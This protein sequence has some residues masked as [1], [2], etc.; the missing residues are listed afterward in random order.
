MEGLKIQ[1]Q[2]YHIRD[3]FFGWNCVEQ[4]GLKAIRQAAECAH[5]EAQWFY[6]LL[7]D[8]TTDGAIENTLRR[9]ADI[10]NCHRASCFLA[11]FLMPRNPDFDFLMKAAN[12]A[13]PLAYA[14]LSMK[15]RDND[16]SFITAQLS[17]DQGEREGFFRLAKCYS[18]KKPYTDECLKNEFLNLRRAA[19]LHCTYSMNRLV[20]ALDPKC[21]ERWHWMLKAAKLG[22][23]FQLELII[24]HIENHR[25]LPTNV[26]FLF[27]YKFT[28]YGEFIPNHLP[29]AKTL[30]FRNQMT[31]FKHFYIQQCAAAR[32]AVNTFS[33]CGFC[34]KL[35]KDLRILIGKFVWAMRWDADYQEDGEIVCSFVKGKTQTRQK[36]WVLE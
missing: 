31:K 10:N 7:K 24:L 1:R 29:F 18:L 32:L 3:M 5:L 20:A 25:T 2:W 6:N 28:K 16:Q 19:R 27:G 15:T 12:Q 8:C 4:N 34:L 35:Y 9:A 23:T 21:M 26:Q 33:L 36:P 30:F 13:N 14:K 22:N 11:C 17:A